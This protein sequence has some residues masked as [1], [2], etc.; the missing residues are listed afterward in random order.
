[1]FLVLNVQKQIN[2]LIILSPQDMIKDKC[3]VIYSLFDSIN[4][5]GYMFINIPIISFQIVIDYF[6]EGNYYHRHRHPHRSYHCRNRCSC[7][8]LLSWSLSLWQ[9]SHCDMF[10]RSMGKVELY[11]QGG[12]N[13]S[14][15]SSWILIN[16]RNF[17]IF[18]DL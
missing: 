2:L 17:D 18:R 3:L 11:I 7:R 14:S 12:I 8:C 16:I 10:F 6:N 1:M 9:L 5:V 15:S 4:M 13:H